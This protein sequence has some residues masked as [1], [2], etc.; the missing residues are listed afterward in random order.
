MD[1]ADFALL[2]AS[3][4]GPPAGATKP[5]DGV[6]LDLTVE[7][8]PPQPKKPATKPPPPPP[9]KSAPPPPPPPKKRSNAPPPPPGKKAGGKA[10]GPPPPPKGGRKAVEGLQRAPEV[11]AMF[12]EMRK[13]LLG[14]AA[15]GAGGPKKIGGGGSADPAALMEELAKNS[16]YAAQVQADIVQY[17]SLIEDL[18]KEVSGF[19]ASDMKDIVEFVKRVDAF[20]AE[21]SDE[22]AVL[23]QF[24]W[25]ARYYTM[26]EAK[27]LYE[28]LEKM[29][30]TFKS[31]QKTAKTAT[32]ELK[33][34]QKF[35][36]KSKNRVD[37]IL[38]T[39][40]ADEKKFKENKI[41][42]NAKIYTEVKIASLSL[43]I[44]YM[45]IVLAEVESV[46]RAAPQQQ[47]SQRSK[48][49]EKS[50]GLLTGQAISYCSPRLS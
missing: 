3:I 25:P 1:T 13:A 38:R 33:I 10:G 16:K 9:K 5:A 7:E 43:L 31:W 2:A 40:D 42:W 49:I 6:K 12:Q 21:L 8:P 15:K 35:M 29:K 4:M 26:L 48:A 45:E 23:K 34:V 44:V 47:G 22:T 32:D 20:L 14:S 28:E 37:V 27:G 50:M 11:I 36:D 46:M 17:S 24:D 18:I 39:K 30:K 41:P 19:D